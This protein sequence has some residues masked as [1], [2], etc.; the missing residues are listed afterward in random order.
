MAA[1]APEVVAKPELP[2]AA[3]SDTETNL[4][5]DVPES[6]VVNVE[7]EVCR[8]YTPREKQKLCVPDER[9]CHQID[10]DHVVERQLRRMARMTSEREAKPSSIALKQSL[11]NVEQGTAPVDV[12][13]FEVQDNVRLN[14]VRNSSS[15]TSVPDSGS[16]SCWKLHGLDP[17]SMATVKSYV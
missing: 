13:E 1:E 8:P 3:V 5:N 11:E 6:A 2:D 7:N 4:D 16:S 17:R 15:R 14:P 12:I 10:S 9:S